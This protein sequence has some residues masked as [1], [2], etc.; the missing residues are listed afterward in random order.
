MNAGFAKRSKDTHVLS[1]RVFA[2]VVREARLSVLQNFMH[3]FINKSTHVGGI[4]SK[5]SACRGDAESRE[6]CF[7]PLARM[8][9]R[10]A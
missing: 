7:L 6:R 3:D 9:H 10:V 8:I 4:E 2:L 5:C 1:V